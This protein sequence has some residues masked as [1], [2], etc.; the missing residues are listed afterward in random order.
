MNQ[1]ELDKM[2]DAVYFWLQKTGMINHDAIRLLEHS[3]AQ[4]SFYED[5]HAA[6]ARNAEVYS[7]LKREFNEGPV[8]EN[9]VVCR[10][11]ASFYGMRFVSVAG[12]RTFFQKME[13]LRNNHD[14]LDARLLTVEL[15]PEMGQYQFSFVTKMLNLLDDETY[16][17]YDSQIATVFQIPFV[18]DETRLDRQEAIYRDVTDTYTALREHAA[19]TDFR[20]RFNCPEM[21]TMKVLDA[22][23]WRLGKMLDQDGLELSPSEYL[24]NQ[25][26]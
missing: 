9:P 16:P 15:K 14:G 10:R 1:C 6:F 19:I 24:G 23:F 18:P 25:V 26:Q 20:T 7:L 12:K 22:L 3:I 2:T 8:T 4:P 13:L 17:V 21:G 11:F 5:N